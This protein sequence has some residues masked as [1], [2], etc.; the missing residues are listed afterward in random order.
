M[1]SHRSGKPNS[2]RC[3]DNWK[4][5]KL[6]GTKGSITALLLGHAES[7]TTQRKTLCTS[8]LVNKSW[9]WRS[10]FLRRNETWALPVIVFNFWCPHVWSPPMPSERCRRVADGA[11]HSATVSQP[12]TMCHCSR[13]KQRVIPM[14]VADYWDFCWNARISKPPYPSFRSA[15]IWSRQEN[16][17]NSCCAMLCNVICNSAGA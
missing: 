11:T 9:G 4:T 15:I 12:V 14:Y 10:S 1:K 7:R 17:I 8:M 5:P 13:T 2:P 3:Y 16:S 6:G